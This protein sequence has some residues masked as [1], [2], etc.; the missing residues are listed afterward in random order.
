MEKNNLICI[1]IIFIVLSSSFLLLL[2]ENANA[3]MEP[4]RIIIYSVL[5]KVKNY[6]GKGHL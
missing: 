6:E 3:A 5:P 1:E 4:P 2:T